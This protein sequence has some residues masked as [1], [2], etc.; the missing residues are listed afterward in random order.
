MSPFWWR[1]FERLHGHLG[2]LAAIALLHPAILL[3]R[4][5]R[6]A[7]LSAGM[8]TAMVSVA[9][10]GGM[11][12]YPAYRSQ[13]KQRL[14]QE[15]PA[16]GWLFERKEH[17]AIGA[18]LL[19]WSGLLA[20]IGQPRAT[21]PEIRRLL[22][23]LA[24]R[25]FVVAAL[26]AVAVAALGTVVAAQRSFLSVQLWGEEAVDFFQAARGI[27]VTHWALGS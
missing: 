4:P 16:I 12:I 23:Q 13:V 8:A 10:V 27:R 17:L 7:P 22:G 6:R 20:H 19:A 24:H 15:A 2:W 25:S 3:R 18:F 14:F 9:L 5:L 1:L 26:L 21:D 11:F